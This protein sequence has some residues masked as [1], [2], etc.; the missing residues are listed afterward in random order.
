MPQKSSNGTARK[1]VPG[2]EEMMRKGSTED[3]GRGLELRRA[4]AMLDGL[5]IKTRQGRLHSERTHCG[6]YIWLTGDPS[7]HCK[8]IIKVL[9]PHVPTSCRSSLCLVAQQKFHSTSFQATR[10][11]RQERL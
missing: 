9:M 8:H 11:L 1:A 4:A 3:S 2:E 5:W 7:R 6:L 10:L